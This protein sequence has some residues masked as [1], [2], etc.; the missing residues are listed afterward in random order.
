MGSNKMI[1]PKSPSTQQ[2]TIKSKANELSKYPREALIFHLKDFSTNTLTI[3]P[4]S[5]NNGENDIVIY[6]DGVI[7][8]SNN[9]ILLNDTISF[10]V[11]GI[12][13]IVD[14]ITFTAAN[15]RTF[16]L[17][18]FAND[19]N[20]GVEGFGFTHKPYSTYTDPA[21]SSKG[22]LTTFTGLTSA[23]QFT[24]GARVAI[25]NTV[26]TSPLY[27]WNWGAI[28]SI[29]SNTS[30][31][32]QMDNNSSYG[33]NLTAATG[34]EILQW[35]KFRPW[36]VASTGQTLYKKSYRLL[37]E[38]FSNTSGN[39]DA[40][41]RVDDPFRPTTG[42]MVVETT[43]TVGSTTLSAGRYI[44]IWAKTAGMRCTLQETST[45]PATM[46]L[47]DSLGSVTLRLTGQVLS[48][49]IEGHVSNLGL[50][51]YARFTWL[52]GASTNSQKRIRLRSYQVNGGMAT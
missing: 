11:T 47:I 4:Q 31:Q 14:G 15:A 51:S 48:T 30:I 32:V 50:S 24:E 3:S 38:I 6:C 1:R 18:F 27:E 7:Y 41:H 2:N 43:G 26:G 21:S 28:E 52:A 49:N 37:G 45:L 19:A 23:Y 10:G 17:W 44:P 42:D 8:D 33:T 46:D 39:I 22:A 13:G 36:V 20:N 29:V 25:R 12:G 40:A 16:L 9:G 34:G 5:N 35:D